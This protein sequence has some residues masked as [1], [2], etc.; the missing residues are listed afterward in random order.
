MAK[1]RPKLT[2]E[3]HAAFSRKIV[4]IARELF[5]A[6][7]FEG[8]SIRKIAER[9]GCSPMTLYRYFENKHAILRHIWLDIFDDAARHVR[10]SIGGESPGLSQLRSA[11]RSY[12]RYWLDHPTYFYIIFLNFDPASIALGHSVYNDRDSTVRPVYELFES[13]LSDCAAKGDLADIPIPTASQILFSNIY[14]SIMSLLTIPE[15]FQNDPDKFSQI[16][17]E[18]FIC[19]F[20]PA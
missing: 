13:I 9:A 14:G 6:E 12:I 3:A 15:Y 4:E 5:L 1:G 8:V 17:V 19:G 7:G 2:A 11:A 10:E 16:L 20:R 18:H